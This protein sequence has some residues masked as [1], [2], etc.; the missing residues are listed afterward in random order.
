MRVK[1]LEIFYLTH[2]LFEENVLH[3]IFRLKYVHCKSMLFLKASL[4]L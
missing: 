2:L 4:M 3:A 1:L